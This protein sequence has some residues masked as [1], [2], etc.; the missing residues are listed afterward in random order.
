MLFDKT[1]VFFLIAVCVEI[2]GLKDLTRL[3]A[4]ILKATFF[5]FF[6]YVLF[7]GHVFYVQSRSF[8]MICTF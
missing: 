8:A 5:E 1:S 2:K 6:L 3:S 7:P 4:L